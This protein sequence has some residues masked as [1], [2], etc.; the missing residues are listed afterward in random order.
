MKALAILILCGTASV[1][2]A[3]SRTLPKEV[4]R[5]IAERNI[6]DHFR[7]EP[8]EGNSP[9]QIER[10]EFVIDSLDIYCSGTDKRLAALK[11]RHKNN[12]AAMDK[13]NQY[14]EKIEGAES[15]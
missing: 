5:F 10:R 12:R 6:C 13:L 15:N 8:A 11:R 9:E 2:V 14:E 1:A 7:G 3:Q 4:K